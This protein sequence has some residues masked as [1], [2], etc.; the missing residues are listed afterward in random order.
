MDKALIRSRFAK[1]SESYLQHALVQRQIA[2][3]MI[4]LLRRYV[5]EEAHRNVLEI[6]CGT[7]LFTRAYWH[8]WQP[9]H[10]LL[11]D[12]C[13]E[14]VC[15]FADL[16]QG[17][18]RFVAKDAETLD[19]PSGQDLIVSCSALQWFEA[20]VRFLSGCRRLL[21]A[22]GYLAFS[23]FGPRNAE[24]V[25]SLTA[26][27]L[28][29]RSLDEL[30]TALSGAYRIVHASEACVRL[31]FPAPLD[32]LRH[33]KATGV[34]GIRPCRWTRKELADFCAR[35]AARYAAP[36]GGV[37]LTYHPMYVICVKK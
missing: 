27:G 14:V 17:R 15:F 9:E 31:S 8:N 23:T 18:V 36:E 5:P 2:L 16:P 30:R 11:N 29:Y 19:F 34:T 10:L 20:P 32:V 22:G 26:S 37:T 1:A 7:G 28:P 13:P 33:L 4:V 21:S 24:E 6:G 35:Y 3:R 25:R 12:L